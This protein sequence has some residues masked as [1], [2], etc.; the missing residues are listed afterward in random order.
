MSMRW[1]TQ[2]IGI[3]EAIFFDPLYL[4]LLMKDM[5]ELELNRTKRICVCGCECMCVWL[6]GCVGVFGGGQ[7][8]CSVRSEKNHQGYTLR[9]AS[10]HVTSC[11]KTETKKKR[12][13]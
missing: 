4:N 10:F 13:I 7:L 3:L 11:L 9:Y 6:C 5:L 2:T 12:G 1:K 8:Y